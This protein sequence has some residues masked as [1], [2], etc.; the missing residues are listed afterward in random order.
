MS[1]RIYHIFL[2]FLLTGVFPVAGQ[3][4]RTVGN[5]IS[6]E[7]DSLVKLVLGKYRGVPGWQESADSLTWIAIAGSSGDTLTVKPL[8][9]GCFR[10]V[11][12]EGTCRPVWSGAVRI[13]FSPPRLTTDE[14][15]GITPTTAQ[16]GGRVV[17][18][19]GAPVTARGVCRSLHENP[20]AAGICTN[21]GT[22]TGSYVSQLTG[23][24]SDTLYYVRAYAQNSK[25]IAYGNQITFRTPP[26]QDPNTIKD[27]DG[28][29]YP[30]V[31]IGNQV[32]M[33]ENLRVT[34][35]PD[36]TPLNSYVVEN[37]PDN[38]LIYGRH[39]TWDVAMNGSTSQSAQGIC[40]DGWHI[41]SDEEWK[42]LEIAL[43]MTRQQ[44][45][46]DNT[47]RG[48]GIG[49]SMKSGGNSGLNI[50]MAGMYAGGGFMYVNQWAYIYS[51]TEAGGNAWRRCLAAS[52]STAGR[53]NSF[54]KSYGFS[55]RCVKNN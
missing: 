36:G 44:A 46:L 30:V 48:D 29:V 9:E 18:D 43:G 3:E 40:P 8:R 32:W 27:I 10:A 20:A 6:L 19:G 41:P 28:N 38:A 55:V 53:Y 17:S 7:G 33:A 51:S 14:A 37:N 22:G 21:D 5:I 50:P 45:D 15:T 35:A 39:Y 25:G 42:I 11:V 54:P 31:R 4:L 34:K 13:L 49:T 24:I 2:S 23:L 47:W 16:C 52:Y 1:Q 12:S 26:Q